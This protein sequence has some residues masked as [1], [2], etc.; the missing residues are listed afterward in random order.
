MKGRRL[1]LVL[2]ASVATAVFPAGGAKA[3]GFCS[4]YEG[5]RLTDAS[6][7]TVEMKGN[8]FTPTVLRVRPGATVTFSN[9]D[10]EA[11]AV[12]GA[13]GSFGDMHR[14][15]APGKSVRYRF[16][17]E[18]TFPYVCIFHPGMAGA[19]VVGDGEGPD[20]SGA[21]GILVPPSSAGN[22]RASRSPSDADGGPGAAAVIA[23]L[24]F[25]A[26]LAGVVARLVRGAHREAAVGPE[27]A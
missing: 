9:Q 15:I 22:D 17:D 26:V 16:E 11:H 21:T 3:G 2:V 8:C 19:I 27:G 14:E 23:A 13:A 1:V 4:G 7:A 5:E 10:P 25:L 18:G 20:A 12:G 6:G 24:A